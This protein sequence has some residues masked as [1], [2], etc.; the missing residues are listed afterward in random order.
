MD[1]TQPLS[2]LQAMAVAP[3]NRQLNWRPGEH[4]SY[5]NA[6]AGLVS[7]IIE[8]IVMSDDGETFDSWFDREIL[9]TLGM[10]NSSL[11]WTQSLQDS[12]VQGYDSDLH[13]PIPYWHTLF[14][15]FGGLNSTAVDM[16]RLLRLLLND[17]V[18]DGQRLFSS[19]SMQRMLSP[20]ETLMARHGV[21]QGRGLGISVRQY[22]GQWIYSHN[23][24]ADGYLARIAFNL[25][26]KRAYYVVINAYRHDLLA[27]FVAPL[28]NWLIAGLAA[29]KVAPELALDRA[30][31]TALLGDY[32]PVTF[33]FGQ[34]AGGDLLQVFESGGRLYWRRKGDDERTQMIAVSPTLLRTSSQ[35][36]PSIA[37]VKG[38]D[39]LDYLQGAFG[40]YRKLQ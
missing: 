13:S 33:R 38:S 12:L 40:S 17:G 14:R 29:N 4:T 7:T 5:S 24:D 11:V 28:D 1:Y 39:G 27:E 35:F 32:E 25:Q 19:A 10:S 8:N 34:R 23:G 26:S 36:A 30:Q 3:Q 2:L 15:A 9:Q 37:L 20:S 16:S 6:G 22:K 31:L 21:K 18:L